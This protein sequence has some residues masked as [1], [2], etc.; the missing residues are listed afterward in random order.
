[1]AQAKLRYQLT[2]EPP[3]DQSYFYVKVL[4]REAPD[5]ADFTQAQLVL[6]RT[7]L[8]PRRVWFLQPNGNEVTWDFNK[9]QSGID[10]PPALFAQPNLP[11]GWQWERNPVDSKPNKVRSAGQ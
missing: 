4:P 5:K 8:L 7:N 6:F 11:A 3:P 2:L 9:V 1:A 10:I